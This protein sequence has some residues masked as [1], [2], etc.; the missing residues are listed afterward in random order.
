MPDLVH[1]E[2]SLSSPVASQSRRPALPWLFS[3]SVDLWTFLGSAALA[4]GLLLLGGWRGWLNNDS[5]EW[6]W[7]TSVVLIDVAHVYATGFRVYFDRGELHRRPWLYLLV[8]LLAF[9]I[10]VAVYT[11]GALLFWRT[12]AYLA[13]FHFVRQ[14]YGWVALYRAK[15]GDCGLAGRMIDST[16]I[17][18]ATIYPLVYWHC[19]PRRFAWFVATD[20]A[21]L[22]LLV[23]RILAP[24]YWI[25]LGL[26]GA[27]AIHQAVWHKRFN[28]GKDIVV[29][30]TAV[31]WYV[32]IVS[33]NSDYAFTVTNVITHGVPYMVLVFW[34][35]DHRQSA[36]S[37][38]G[39][40]P[41]PRWSRLVSFI[42]VL[43]LLA[44][45]EEL[46]WDCGVWH[47]RPWLFGPAWNIGDFDQVLVPLLA[48]PQVTHY[49]LDGFIWKRR[50]NPDVAENCRSAVQTG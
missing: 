37:K 32:G 24:V 13:V 48:V 1:G 43:W 22:P 46:F 29:F 6:L 3:A 18:L 7:I 45:I 15:A 16:A 10:G 50:S 33:F 27:R 23:E 8:P 42:G 14:Q 31:C 19:H 25:A 47:E 39:A 21:E 12:L 2:C 20:F 26:Y 34:Y 9:V 36:T 35:R 38:E 40:A 49:I 5:P 44:Y 28:P 11:E 17:Y 30:T 4:L 41:T